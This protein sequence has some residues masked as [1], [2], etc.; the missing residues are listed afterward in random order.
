MTSPVQEDRSGGYVKEGREGRLEIGIV[1]VG[2]LRY[3]KSV[4]GVDQ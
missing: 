4:R 1:Q 3:I 2:Y